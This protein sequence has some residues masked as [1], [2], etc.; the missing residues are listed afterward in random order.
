M[1]FFGKWQTIYGSSGVAMVEETGVPYRVP[2]KLRWPQ[3]PAIWPISS[4]LENQSQKK[5]TWRRR[6]P[7][8]G[9]K[10]L[11]LTRVT[12]S[13]TRHSQALCA[14]RTKW[15]HSAKPHPFDS[16]DTTVQYVP[17]HTS[18]TTF[19][20]THRTNLLNNSTPEIRLS[21]RHYTKSYICLC[22]LAEKRWGFHR[23]SK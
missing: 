9:A 19:W 2:R 17:V 6:K 12:I 5:R 8:C 7:D 20:E 11:F 4:S 10:L 16:P 1:A 15:Q 22:L 13:P 21:Y 3:N 18:E 23:F 14:T